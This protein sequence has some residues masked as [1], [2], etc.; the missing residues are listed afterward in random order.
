MIVISLQGWRLFGHLAIK[1]CW[2]ATGGRTEAL[3]KAL[4]LGLLVAT[5]QAQQAQQATNH[6]GEGKNKL[7]KLRSVLLGSWVCIYMK[8]VME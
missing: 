6:L 5:A 2:A 8:V 3:G 4:G 7:T 1:K